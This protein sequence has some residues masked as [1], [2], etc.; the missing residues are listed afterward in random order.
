MKIHQYNNKKMN[1]WKLSDYNYNYQ[2]ICETGVYWST[3]LWILHAI[4]QISMEINITC[5]K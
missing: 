5:V 2:I 3:L 4:D 1:R